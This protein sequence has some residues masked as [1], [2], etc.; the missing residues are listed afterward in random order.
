[1]PRRGSSW[2]GKGPDGPDPIM[3]T[4]VLIIGRHC[5]PD[6][7][8]HLLESGRNYEATRRSTMRETQAVSAC[9]A[10]IVISCSGAALAQDDVMSFFLT[11][12]GSGDGANLG[13][14]RGADRHCP[15]LAEEGGG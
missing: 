10:L 3:P 8:I 12:V 7:S 11:S 2:G 1:M 15:E 13:G 14:I 5:S 9:I 6:P 4:W